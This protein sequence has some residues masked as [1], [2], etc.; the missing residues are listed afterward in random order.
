FTQYSIK[1]G[2]PSVVA[3]SVIVAQDGS[4]WSATKAGVAHLQNG[5]FRNYSMADGLSSDRIASVFQ[6]YKGGIWAATSAGIDRLAGDRFVALRGAEDVVDVPYNSLHE[7]S[8]G[9]LYAL[10]LTDGISRIANTQIFNI[11][12]T[13]EVSWMTQGPGHDLWFSGR[14]G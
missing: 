10:S 11:H 13:M 2:F 8:S 7:D 1:E 12:H 6:D 4:I 3:L 5:H 9:N 14:Q